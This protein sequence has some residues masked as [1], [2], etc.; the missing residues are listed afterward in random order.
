MNKHLLTNAKAYASLLGTVLTA[1]S[2]VYTA[3]SRVGHV[4]TAVLAVLTALGVW[5]VPNAAQDAPPGGDFSVAPEA[6]APPSA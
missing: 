5:A 2:G 1:L 3:D 6:P 4:V